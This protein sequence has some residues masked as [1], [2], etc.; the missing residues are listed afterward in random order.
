MIISSVNYCQLLRRQILTGVSFYE[1]QEVLIFLRNVAPFRF[2][3]GSSME[4]V[5]EPLKT[6]KLL[7]PNL[8]SPTFIPHITDQRPTINKVFDRFEM[9]F[10]RFLYLIRWHPTILIYFMHPHYSH[11][12]LN[13]SI[14]S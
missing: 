13:A 8:T 11:L 14:K 9:F 5:L 12:R 10:F 4:E 1:T 7:L 6:P 2:I 3:C